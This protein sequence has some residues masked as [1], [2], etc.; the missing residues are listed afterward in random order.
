VTNNHQDDAL[1][2]FQDRDLRLIGVAERHQGA[3]RFREA[4]PGEHRKREQ[5]N[6]RSRRYLRR[7]HQG[8]EYVDKER[9]YVFR[10]ARRQL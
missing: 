1:E 3:Y 7:S 10:R 4:G 6:R 2:A 9:Y 8:L 5:A